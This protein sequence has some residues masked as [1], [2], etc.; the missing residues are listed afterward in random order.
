MLSKFNE[1]T[2][3]AIAI[4]ESIAFD[5]GHMSV[6]TEHLLLA[7]LKV[8]ESKLRTILNNYQITYEDLKEQI[9]SLFGKKENKTYYMEYTSSLKQIMEHAILEGRKNGEDKVSLDT[10]AYSL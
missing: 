4:A 6:G 7:F 2:Q 3:K 9:I 1:K 5:L 8:R 10:L